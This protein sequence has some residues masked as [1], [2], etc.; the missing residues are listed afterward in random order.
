MTT[1]ASLTRISRTLAGRLLLG[2][3][4]ALPLVVQ[5]E[6]VVLSQGATVAGKTIG[7]WTAEWWQWAVS[8]SAPN[9][10]F[11]DT[12]GANAG[13]GQSGPVFFL[14]GNPT[15]TSSRTFS[16]AAGKSLLL[17]LVN[18]EWSQH[19]LG[20]DKTPQ[21][22][23]QAASDFAD[24]IDSLHATI[25]GQAVPDLFSHRE[26]SPDFH[27]TAVAGNVVGVPAGES[28][29][30]VG[31]GY[32]LMISGLKPGVH[33]INFGGSISSIGLSINDTDT[34]RVP[35]PGSL[36]LAGLALGILVR[37]RH[38]KEPSAGAAAASLSA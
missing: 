5:A 27:F 6:P 11:T 14:G 13:L 20:F 8:F 37:M 34:I 29:I 30:A 18:V 38:R 15:G 22:I 3:A 21:E 33:T 36:A 28:G 19:E 4:V 25:D 24:Q 31:N 1:P 10:P 23:R 32:Y 2:L 7:E 17:P 9:D 12:T 16:V 26:S 35:E